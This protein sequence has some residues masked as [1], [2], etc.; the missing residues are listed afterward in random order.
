MSLISSRFYPTKQD[1]AWCWCWLN[2][3]P[4]SSSGVTPGLRCKFPVR[5]AATLKG[6]ITTVHSKHNK[7]GDMR[8]TKK[9]LIERPRR[10]KVRIV[11]L[12]LRNVIRYAQIYR[13]TSQGGFAGQSNGP[14]WEVQK[15]TFLRS[16]HPA[17]VSTL[18]F[19][20]TV[21]E[22][23]SESDENDPS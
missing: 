5:N 15:G 18:C 4:S 11:G 23:Q 14:T 6:H 21:P 3:R 2:F 19:Y 8:T 12:A 17:I 13:L 20:E 22:I 1:Q 7:E 16:D 10:R 9:R